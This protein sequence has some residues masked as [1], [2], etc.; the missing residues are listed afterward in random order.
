MVHAITLCTRSFS[1]AYIIYCDLSHHLKKNLW[2]AHSSVAP[3]LFPF[4]FY[5][6][7]CLAVYLFCFQFSIFS[8]G[9]IEISFSP[10][11][12]PTRK[13]FLLKS[14]VT[15]I[16]V[17]PIVSSSSTCYCAYE[18]HLPQLMILSLFETFPAFTG[19]NSLLV[20]PYSPLPTTLPYSLL[21]F[22]FLLTS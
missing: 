16:L 3:I 5:G 21:L 7:T 10:N 6:K 12:T 17:N 19:Q 22:F 9:P 11:P 18:Q 13:L 8:L 14:L 15:S 20:L 4:S 2:T 1:L